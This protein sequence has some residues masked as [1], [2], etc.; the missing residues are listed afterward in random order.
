MDDFWKR[1]LADGA[2]IVTLIGVLAF[3]VRRWVTEAI[4]HHFRTS[5]EESKASLEIEKQKGLSL[6]ERRMAIYPEMLEI[7]YRLRNYMRDCL[8]LL[9]KV[10]DDNQA[11]PPPGYLRIGEELY[12][13][14]Q[15]LY[16]YR[17]FIDEDIFNM[18]HRYK[19]ILQDA[20]VLLDRMDRPPEVKDIE[21]PSELKSEYRSGVMAK[22][23]ESIDQ[24]ERIYH[25]VDELYPRIKESVKR[26][27]ESVLKKSTK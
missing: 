6:L 17:A 7:V 18:L 10:K 1:V 14:T 22:Y 5:F 21:G 19:R 20:Q 25:E 26:H 2:I 24:L 4:S 13:L 23:E 9:Q 15:N 8:Q 27:I 16:K 3:L 11:M 12:L